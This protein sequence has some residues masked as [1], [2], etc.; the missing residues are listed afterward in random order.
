MRAGYYSLDEAAYARS[1]ATHKAAIDRT[2]G[3]RMNI[4]PCL[5]VFFIERPRATATTLTT[6]A[7]TS[8]GF[9]LLAPIHFQPQGEDRGN[10]GDRALTM[11]GVRRPWGRSGPYGSRFR[12]VRRL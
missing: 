5:R 2:L 4:R 9:G 11:A 1:M 7:C 6:W 3:S 10:H 8:F 12:A